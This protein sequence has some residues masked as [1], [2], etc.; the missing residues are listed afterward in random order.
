MDARPNATAHAA[1]LLRAAQGSD[2]GRQR[3]DDVRSPSATEA[4]PRADDPWPGL[5]RRMRPGACGSYP[6]RTCGNRV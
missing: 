2:P 4:G 6:W 5:E 1:S 3:M